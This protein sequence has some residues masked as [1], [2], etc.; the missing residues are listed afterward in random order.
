MTDNQSP[1]HRWGAP[2]QIKDDESISVRNRRALGGALYGFLGGSAFA[3]L[4]GAIDMLTYPDLPIFTDW[5]AILARWLWAGCGLAV[6]GAAAGWF[7]EKLKGITIGASI[8]ASAMLIVSVTQARFIP[9]ANFI[10]LVILILPVAA[11]C[12]P[13]TILLRWLANKHMDTLEKSGFLRGRGIASLV[14]LALLLGLLPGALMRTSGKAEQSLRFMNTLLTNAAAGNVD[15]RFGRRLDQLPTFKA[16][17]G[18]DYKLSQKL[19]LLS[20]EGYEIE[21][22]FEDGYQVTCTIIIYGSQK[23]YIFDC[24]E[25]E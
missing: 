9:M 8:L 2:L 17:L 11:T 3:L 16:H 7:T 23:P 18:A 12:I 19:S 5:P 25:R 6:V 4:S 1:S 21:T 13:I 20:T 24:A 15:T 22:T 14:F 10:F